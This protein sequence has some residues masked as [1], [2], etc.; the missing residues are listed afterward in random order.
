MLDD[1]ILLVLPELC[2]YRRWT[3]ID[4]SLMLVILSLGIAWRC[5]TTEVNANTLYWYY[6]QY[7]M[8]LFS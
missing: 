3:I 6:R 1:L 7:I 8:T 2:W 5:R 4:K